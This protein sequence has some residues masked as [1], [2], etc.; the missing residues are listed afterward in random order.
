[1]E[2]LSVMSSL[3]PVVLRATFGEAIAPFSEFIELLPVRLL[4]LP[5]DTKELLR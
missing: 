2:P 3:L 5:V 4:P 1:M